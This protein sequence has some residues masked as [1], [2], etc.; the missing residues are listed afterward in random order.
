MAAINIAASVGVARDRGLA[1]GQRVAQ[2][3][4]IWLIPVAGAITTVAVRRSQ[5]SATTSK[6]S[7][8]MTSVY[9]ESQAID[10]AIGGR[11]PESH[12]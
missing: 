3:I 9:A 12:E 2:F 8:P 10:L 7:E 1:T 5:T 4:L 6:P 11:N